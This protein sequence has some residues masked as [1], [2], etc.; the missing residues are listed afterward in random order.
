MKHCRAGSRLEKYYFAV[1]NPGMFTAVI[2]ARNEPLALAATLGPLVRGVVQGL[3]GSAILVAQDETPALHDIADSAGCRVLI[4][5][6]WP[7]GFARAVAV[8]GGAPLIVID[9][10]VMLGQEFWPLLADHMPLLGDRPAVTLSAPGNT[11]FGALKRLIGQIGGGVDAGSALLLPISTA[12][13][14]A[15]AKADPF[16]FRYGKS[17]IRLNAGASRVKLS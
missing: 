12:R 4:S 17:L 11:P 9:T 6:T 5:P 16:A 15:Q 2:R 10:G 7:E 13:M 3:V 14:I 8:T 1:H